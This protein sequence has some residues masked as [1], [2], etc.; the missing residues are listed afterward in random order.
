MNSLTVV[1]PLKVTT[2][3]TYVIKRLEKLIN[4]F[5]RFPVEVV[6]S[7]ATII[8]KYIK[9]VQQI[10]INKDN[11]VYVNKAIKGIY[12]A[13]TSRNTGV[14]HTNGEYLLFFDVDLIIH[15]DFMEQLNSDIERIKRDEIKFSIYPSLYLSEHYT[16]ILHTHTTVTKLFFEK[17][18]KS[19]QEGSNVDVLYNAINTSTIL[20][21]KQTFIS[22]GKF[23]E[24]FVGHGYEDF[25]LIHRLFLFENNQKIGKDYFEDYKTPFIAHYKGFRKYYLVKTL[26]MYM[27][28]FFTM[29]LYHPRPLSKLYY[30]NRINNSKNFINMIKNSVN[31]EDLNS[32]ELLNMMDIPHIIIGFYELVEDR[33]KKNLILKKFKKL[34]RDPLLFFK[35]M[36]KI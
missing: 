3:N 23:D 8:K 24:S 26:P 18:N 6:I 2:D 1:I 9:S 5:E 29:H 32:N 30:K 7:D 25:E 20:V 14:E 16:N 13:A 27:N 10:I 19:F 4:Y 35:D 22:V 36:I 31:Y 34:M 28:G 17:A 15:D 21:K 12:S 33:N 11:V